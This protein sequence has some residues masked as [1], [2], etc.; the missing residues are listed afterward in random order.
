MHPDVT[1]FEAMGVRV[2]VGGAT[3]AEASAVRGLFEEWEQAFSRFRQDSELSRINRH[4]YEVVVV[5]PLFARVTRVALRAAA[6]TAGRVDPTLGAAIEAAGYDRD[7]SLLQ[8]DAPAARSP[9]RG[10]WQRLRLDGCLLYRPRGVLLDLNCVVKAMAVDAALDL[11]A[12]DGFVSAGGDLAVRG[13]LDVGL[14]G[15][16]SVAVHSSGVATSGSSRRRWMRGGDVQHHL[17]DPATGRPA[18]S[19]WTDVTVAAADCTTA[20][21]AAKTAYLLS[22][23]GPAWIEEQ[24][25]AARFLAGTGE[26]VD[27]ALAA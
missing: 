12:G 11:L 18:R 13:S 22:S 10:C 25:L 16:G 15:G 4:A 9:Q 6:S 2:R 1:E 24:G 8:H 26:I 27:V 19:R 3:A 21:V 20:D 17:L 7:F 23:E 14:P 5:S